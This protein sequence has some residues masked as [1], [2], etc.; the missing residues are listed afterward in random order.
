VISEIK[1]GG[2]SHF[3]NQKSQYSCNKLTNFDEIWHGNVPQ[4]STAQ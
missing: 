2:S 1:N 4:L 3:E